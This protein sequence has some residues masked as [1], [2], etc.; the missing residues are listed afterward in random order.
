M[1]ILSLSDNENTHDAQDPI[2]VDSDDSEL[3][4]NEI[5]AQFIAS[6]SNLRMLVSGIKQVK[7]S[8]EKD[9]QEFIKFDE[10]I[11]S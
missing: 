5:G 9:L 11:N 8:L 6:I 1:K 2:Y 3:D 4:D 7:E 10:E